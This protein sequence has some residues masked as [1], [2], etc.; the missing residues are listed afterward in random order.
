MIC[1]TYFSLL[2]P[3]KKA[4]NTFICLYYQTAPLVV[5]GFEYS[6]RSCWYYWYQYLPLSS[7]TIISHGMHVHIYQISIII[8]PVYSRTT[9]AG[10]WSPQTPCPCPWLSQSLHC[11]YKSRLC[12]ASLT[13]C[14][15]CCPAAK[16]HHPELS[17]GRVPHLSKDAPHGTIDWTK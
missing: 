17:T 4:A 11:N 2:R 16:W 9:C 10:P 3:H 7:A 14:P 6:I 8:L 1:P 13:G 5:F 12:R 15:S